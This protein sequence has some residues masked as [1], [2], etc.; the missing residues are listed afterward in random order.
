MPRKDRTIIIDGTTYNLDDGQPVKK[1]KPNETVPKITTPAAGSTKKRRVANIDSISL[2]RKIQ[3]PLEPHKPP[4]SQ[5]RLESKKDEVDKVAKTKE[6]AMFLKKLKEE[7]FTN[8][9]RRG[10]RFTFI[11]SEKS[12]NARTF[13]RN[14]SKV[15]VTSYK[16]ISALDIYN[17]GLL[18]LDSAIFEQKKEVGKVKSEKIVE[19]GSTKIEKTKTKK[20][21]DKSA[22]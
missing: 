11:L 17:G 21:S 5:L 22:I 4:K 2:K 8:A 9:P 14:I 20:P 16:D 6:F 19:K 7:R 13:L 10:A 12:L 15:V 1:V 3:K 18:I